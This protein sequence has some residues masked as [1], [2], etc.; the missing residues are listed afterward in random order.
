MFLAI[1]AALLLSLGGIF[2]IWRF[3]L[4]HPETSPLTNTSAEQAAQS[5]SGAESTSTWKSLQATTTEYGYT[6]QNNSVYFYGQMTPSGRQQDVSVSTSPTDFAVSDQN[7]LFGKDDKNVFFIGR[8]IPNADPNTFFVFDPYN[9][10]GYAK[11]KGQVYLAVNSSTYASVGGVITIPNVDPATFTIIEHGYTK[12]KN[13]V[14]IQKRCCEIGV[15][16]LPGADP[17]TFHFFGLNISSLS[18]SDNDFYGFYAKDKNNVYYIDRLIAGADSTFDFI[19]DVDGNLTGYAKDK[20]HIYNA[21]GGNVIENADPTTFVVLNGTYAKDKN[22]VYSYNADVFADNVFT[23]GML[24]KN[25]DPMTFEIV[26]NQK[27]YDAKDKN[28]Y[29]FEGKIVQ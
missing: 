12:D 28:H 18:D 24:V 19:R 11:D 5:T 15:S 6:L 13:S 20:N 14:Y 8:Q 23:I 3:D 16:I 21:Y 10:S 4:L 7:Y 26:S 25:A 27:T 22:A 17:S 9:A 29:F 1:F 2:V